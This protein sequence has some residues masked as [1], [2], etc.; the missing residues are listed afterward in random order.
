MTRVRPCPASRL[1]ALGLA[2]ARRPCSALAQEDEGAFDRTPQDCVSRPASTRPTRSTIRTSF[3]K[4]ATATS[5]A[6][7]CRADVPGWSART[8]SRTRSRAAGDSAASTRSRCSR[9]HRRL[10]RRNGLPFRKDSPAVSASSCRC[11]RRRSRNW[12]YAR[13][14]RRPPD[15]E[16]D[17]DNVGRARPTARAVETMTPT[18]RRRGRDRR[19]E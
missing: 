7:T 1:V 10:R 18:P 2:C 5:I 8:A 6:T 4:C 19:R 15:A 17:R 9:R 12:N 16:H 3:S 13:R 14:R 11:R